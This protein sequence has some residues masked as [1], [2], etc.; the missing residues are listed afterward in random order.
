MT[1]RRLV[2]LAL[3]WMTLVP[4]LPSA[5]DAAEL[6][7]R[8]GLLVAP[9]DGSAANRV[10]IQIGG[11]LLGVDTGSDAEPGGTRP[12]ITLSTAH[13]AS[14]VAA[15]TP[16]VI[17]L[18]PESRVA[19]S[20]PGAGT[21][22]TFE[23]GF[24]LRSAGRSVVFLDLGR[25]ATA[26]D[27]VLW[28][29]DDRVLIT[30][31]LCQRT[32]VA[33]TPASDTQAWLAALD[34]LAD[35]EPGLVIPGRGTPGGPELLLDQRRRLQ[36]LHDEVLDGV[37]SALTADEI[38]R[39]WD[40]PWWV[41]WWE[42]DED[43]AMGALEAV[44]VE[45]AGRRPPW[46][47]LED[48]K[49]RPG[50]SPTRDDT[51]WSP[52]KKV[53]WRNYWPERLESLELVAPR[54]EIIPYDDA[55][56]A[57]DDI[58]DA[59]ALIG[60][61]TAELLAAGERLRWVQVGSA[62]VERYLV[63]PE[64]ASGEVL[65]T[66]GQKLASEVI[67]EHVMALA[68]GLARGLN[69]A[70]TA[71]EDGEWQRYEIGNNAPLTRLRGKTLLVVGLGGI[72]TEVARLAD[73]AGMRVTA[74]RNSR[75]EGPPFV[76]R[77]GL[78]EDLPAYVADADVVVNCLPLTDDTRGL[79]DTELFALMKPTAFF[80]NVGRGGTV[81]TADLI[82]A[83]QEGTIA[84]AGLDV[85]DPEPLPDGHPLWKAPNLLI[86]PHFA[87]WSDQDRELRWLLY[88]ENLRRFVAGE[89]L[90]SVVDPERGY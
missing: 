11:R 29:P 73:G 36:D 56:D 33:A 70:A 68:L 42:S 24:S 21:A 17:E 60:T 23:Y 74:I 85:T 50:P 79:F 7:L 35:L 59:D 22:A 37:R 1:R 20:A 9:A 61:A 82:A 83:L 10:W 39:A 63:I 30:G 26:G 67:G 41:A 34:R 66:N 27:A 14:A 44:H 2:L 57:L 72:G 64:L 8:P 58:A 46:Q 13:D 55:G 15:A 71:K 86:T 65:L 76:D 5:A 32:G 43:A 69:R 78:G 18:L 89:R 28:L 48:R 6:P 62:G 54:V 52:P 3:C 81:V 84:G 16:A 4:T 88:R 25:A 38:A 45:L 51:D 49:L 80:I 40:E 77:V 31:Q 47:L 90:L 19:F 87:A 75:R 12:D 53:L